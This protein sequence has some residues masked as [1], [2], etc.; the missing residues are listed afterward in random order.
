LPQR[1]M[2]PDELD[3]IA[4]LRRR[5]EEATHTLDAIQSGSVD[6]VVVNGPNGPQIYTLESPDHPF[7][8][9]VEG[10]QEGAL[11]LGRDGTIYYANAFFSTLVG[12]PLSEI[13]GASFSS[14]VAPSHRGNCSSL[15]EQGLAATVKQ[16]LRLEAAG[17]GIPVQVT[18]SPLGHG[19]M[20]SCCA[21]VFD[22]REREQA[23]RARAAREAAEEANAAKDRFLAVLGHELRSP[24][25]TVLGWA[26]ILG[27]RADLDPGVRKAIK[28]IE[29]NA[30]TQAQLISELL[31]VS[32]IIAGKLHLSFEVVDLK[33]VVTA[34]VA[35]CKLILDKGIEIREYLGDE[36]AYVLGDASR[37]QQIV[38]N[39]LGN[40]VKFTESGGQ[41]DVR[42]NHA[43]RHIELTI[44]DTGSGISSD[45][46][47]TIFGLFQQAAQGQRKGGLG[48]GL[49]ISKQ[50]V[51]AHGGKIRVASPGPGQGA[52]A[53]VQ[54]PRVNGPLPSAEEEVLI[55]SQLSDRAILVIDDDADIL[56]LMR[57][58]LEHRGARVDTVQSAAAA[59][60]KLGTQ[61]YDVLVS[62]LGLPEQDGFSLIQ[63]VRAR[64][65]LS[66]AL[67]AVALTGYA[68]EADARLCK[69]AGFELHLVKPIS[70]W[71]VAR[72]ITRL[73]E[74]PSPHQRA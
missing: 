21:M 67:R 11:T 27:A 57:Y 45:Q 10:I 66:R 2:A 20:P 56:E 70:P 37:L 58:A 61:T 71:E 74:Q 19:E 12:R 7:R 17:G 69:D 6:A 35:A 1:P 53:I 49:S 14:F 41:I 55:D 50:L 33:A 23:E 22:L 68:S 48:L 15:V 5:L 65:H 39:L 25:N 13:V 43:E 36:N 59:L 54:L 16:T 46:I 72:A 34:A 64:G 29:R 42:I 60:D 51:E 8:T 18:L 38:S 30:R 40:A 24:L 32:R 44:A 63:E 31:D 26:Q 62:D 52:T 28:T 9:F 47:E 73:L 3:Q 4:E